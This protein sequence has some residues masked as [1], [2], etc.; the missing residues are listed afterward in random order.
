MP[1]FTIDGA[2]E[3][4]N[5]HRDVAKEKG[6][7]GEE[8]VLA[9]ILKYIEEQGCGAVYHSYEYPYAT[10]RQGVFYPGNINLI[11]EKFAAVPSR[12]GFKDEI[13]LLLITDFRIFA[14]EVKARGG[15]WNL[16]NWWS[17]QNGRK[18]DKCPI[19]QAEKH[20]RMLYHQIYEYLPGGSKEYIVPLV[21]FVDKAKTIDSR[22]LDMRTT[23]PV[24]VLNNLRNKIITYNTPLANSLDVP[25]ILDRLR[26]I[27]S[28][29]LYR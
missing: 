7:A 19:C 21:V 2:L 29:K 11:D 25:N 4:M 17:T 8:A 20:C 28:G 12:V 27:G 9:L 14:I 22:S 3:K 26:K 18:L 6:T 24:A 23:V 13:D 15:T 10:N 5:D 1:R 16:Y